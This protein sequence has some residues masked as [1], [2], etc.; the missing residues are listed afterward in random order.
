MSPGLAGLRVL[1][2]TSYATGPF[3]TQLLAQLGA[4]VL[5]LERPPRGD[6][7]RFT[8]P[9]YFQ[10]FN[11]GKASVL[12][13]TRDPTD[14]GLVDE[15]VAGADVFVEGFR[16]GA[17]ER[18]GLGFERL[19]KLRP[20]LVYISVPGFSSAGPNA[21]ARGYD[22]QYQAVA[23]ALAFDPEPD[24]TP[25]YRSPFPIFD[26]AAAMYAVI[27]LLSV[28]AERP[29]EGIRLE[30]PIVAAG[31]AF[32]F[33][34][35][36][37]ALGLPVDRSL[38]KHTY[39]TADGRHLAITVPQDQDFHALCEALGR[40]DLK[41]ESGFADY[42]SRVTNAGRLQAVV[43]EAIATRTAADWMAA[44]IPAGVPVAVVNTPETVFA[45]PEIQSLGLV[46][47][48]DGRH[49]HLPVLGL[50]W[51]ELGPAPGLGADTERVRARG[52]EALNPPA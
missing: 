29:A 16:P 12:L 32:T 6:P 42:R 19:R 25:V 50:P 30:V 22:V 8:T 35:I 31:L 7:E 43:S 9:A 36:M 38:V 1:D 26:Y 46:H 18:A 11:R 10:S 34:A 40:P 27:G 17:A 21:G 13:D 28:V 2:A 47:E 3:M 39:R 4:I 15:L 37:D 24:G 23:G 49:L 33:P 5:K 52:W 51:V 45:D 44:L 20:G 48:E 41:S 14:L